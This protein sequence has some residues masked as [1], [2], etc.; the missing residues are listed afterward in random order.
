M[1]EGVLC[2]IAPRVAGRTIH[3]IMLECQ[4]RGEVVFLFWEAP[5]LWPG[6]MRSRGGVML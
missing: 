6:G 5:V 4:A 1:L 3:I 2:C